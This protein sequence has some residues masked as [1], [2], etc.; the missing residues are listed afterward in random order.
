MRPKFQSPYVKLS[1]AALAY[2]DVYLID[3]GKSGY[4]SLDEMVLMK[5]DCGK[6]DTFEPL[7]T[8]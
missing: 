6:T 3:S 7:A 4:N 8:A 2:S 5:I 1:P